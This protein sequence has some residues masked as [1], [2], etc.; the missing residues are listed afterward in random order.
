MKL[1][2][3]P[4]KY[5]TLRSKASNYVNV[6]IAQNPEYAL[7][8][9]KEGITQKYVGDTLVLELNE[10]VDYMQLQL[11]RVLG[12]NV[13]SGDAIQINIGNTFKVDSLWIRSQIS[14]TTLELS[15][16]E[17]ANLDL[18]SSQSLIVNL[19][20]IK[21]DRLAINGGRNSEL[22]IKDTK[23]QPN[24][25]ILSDSIAVQVLGKDAMKILNK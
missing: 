6:D 22:R 19:D 21:A 3:K 1:V 13:T 8:S 11:P 17:T 4:F 15:G 2:L 10:S 9:A 14:S 16:I 18:Y 12:I 7:L 25:L 23:V 24:Q 5:L 20:R